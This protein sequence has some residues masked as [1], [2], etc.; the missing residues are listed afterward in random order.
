MESVT[1]ILLTAMV[2]AGLWA[3]MTRSLLISAIALAVV[4]IFVTIL[5]FKL[6]SPLAGVFELSV[7]A[8]LITVVFISTISLTKPSTRTELKEQTKNRIKRYWYLPVILVVAFIYMA[9]NMIQPDIKVLAEAPVNDVKVMLW[10][11]RQTDVFGQIVVILTG[12][13]G[14][15]VLFKERPNHD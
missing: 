12:V 13:F 9:F 1:I 7:C 11:L 15:V 6:D 8:G 5:M 14:V 3:V 2:V 4:S 10:Q